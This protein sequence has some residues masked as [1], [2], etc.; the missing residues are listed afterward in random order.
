[1][2]VSEIPKPRLD[3]LNRGLSETKNLTE[4]L[5]VDQSVLLE[6]VA[7]AERMSELKE[8]CAR[9]PKATVPKQI[10]WIGAQVA[11]IQSTQI[12]ENHKSDVVRCWACYALAQKAKSL[13]GALEAVKPFAA[14]AHFGL[15]EIAWMA[16]REAIC[17]DPTQAIEL[18]IPWARARD[19]YLRRFSSEATRPRGVW[20]KHITELKRDPSPARPLLDLLHS[21]PSRYVQDSVANWLNDSAKDCPDWVRKVV[22]DWS[23]RSGTDETKYILKRATRSLD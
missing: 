17:K 8:I 5:A 15:R 10:A 21:D 11:E 4:W 13:R 23:K 3:Q 19:A 6:S 20:A 2:K 22:R 7:K 18:L 1:M 16:V 12:L 14:D 9:L